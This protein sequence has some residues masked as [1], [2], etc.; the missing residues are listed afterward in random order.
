LNR[1]IVGEVFVESAIAPYALPATS[2][3]ISWFASDAGDS[4]KASSS[5]NDCWTEQ[6]ICGNGRVFGIDECCNTGTFAHQGAFEECLGSAYGDE[7]YAAMRWPYDQIPVPEKY[8]VKDWWHNRKIKVTNPANGKSVIL[9]AKD[10]GPNEVTG[11][12][13]DVSK[14]SMFELGVATDSVVNIEFADQ[15]AQLGPVGSMVSIAMFRGPLA[16]KTIMLDPGHGIDYPSTF[17]GTAGEWQATHNISRRLKP[18][19]EKL[20]AKVYET[21]SNKLMPARAEIANDLN[22]DIYISIHFNG[23]TATSANGIEAYYGGSN[24]YPD[25]TSQKDKELCSK[26]APEVK[27]TLGSQY[28]KNPSTGLLEGYWAVIEDTKMPSCLVEM[29][30]MTYIPLSPKQ[31]KG[32]YYS[33]YYDLF[34]TEDYHIAAAEA[35]RDGILNYFMDG[36]F[37]EGDI[38]KE[39]GD[40]KVYLYQGGLFKHIADE[41]SFCHNI[42]TDFSKIREVPQGAISSM[43]SYGSQMKAPNS[44]YAEPLPPAEATLIK[45]ACSPKVYLYTNGKYRWIVDEAT[46]NFFGHSFN[47]VRNV[48]HGRIPYQDIGDPLSLQHIQYSGG[49]SMVDIDYY[50]DGNA[51]VTLEETPSPTVQIAMSK[52]S[53]FVNS[54]E[55]ILSEQ[56]YSILVEE[57]PTYVKVKSEVSSWSDPVTIS[58]STPTCLNAHNLIINEL[59]TARIITPMAPKYQA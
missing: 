26:L 5:G 14:K 51:V 42:G 52:D 53:G 10:W 44:Y 9:A 40:P 2:G 17:T 32:N 19:L 29:E 38:V 22:A 28:H 41:T 25:G 46:F 35:L 8:F 57:T 36:L 1:C 30:F 15:D 48:G 59:N 11:R 4:C 13:I 55:T 37:R 20:G 24:Y 49:A 31:F 3:K 43:N 58:S 47:D 54:I 39:V 6:Y 45:E 33:T 16:G 27:N 12:V 18:M 50:P 23:A 7:W 56:T 34:A 21:P